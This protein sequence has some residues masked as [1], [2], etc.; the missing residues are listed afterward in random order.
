[1]GVWDED[2]KKEVLRRIVREPAP[3]VQSAFDAVNTQE[4]L[5]MKKLSLA[6]VLGALLLTLSGCGEQG[7]IDAVKKTIIPN[8]SGKTMERLVSDVLEKPVWGYEEA[9][10]GAKYVTVN[11]TLAG[12]KLPDW[13][14]SNKVMDTQFRFSLDP[15]SSAY[16]PANLDGMPSLTS[17]EGI[18]QAY[19]AL[20]CS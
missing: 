7:K 14:K 4:N 16:D 19:K 20:T 11:G 12:D 17:P 13:F 1:M 3:S 5:T 18:L 15:K 8:C 10:G 6:L 9:A 2:A